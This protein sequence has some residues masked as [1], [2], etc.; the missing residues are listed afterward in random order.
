MFTKIFI[1]VMQNFSGSFFDADPA[2][3]TST[4]TTPPSS[5]A[6]PVD[7]SSDSVDLVTSPTSL[8]SVNNSPLQSTATVLN[9]ES[10]EVLG[11]VADPRSDN[12]SFMVVA[13]S[14]SSTP[15]S[16]FSDAG[17]ETIDESIANTVPIIVD[18]QDEGQ[19][20]IEEE[21]EENS[22]SESLAVTIMEP[23]MGNP[24]SDTVTIP[25]STTRQSLHLNL[26]KSNDST[27]SEQTLINQNV[28]TDSASPTLIRSNSQKSNNNNPTV[29]SLENYEMQTEFSDSTHSFEEV[30]R[31]EQPATNTSSGDELETATSSDIEIISNP[32]GCDGNSST[33]SRLSPLKD[34]MGSASVGGGGHF[35]SHRGHSRYIHFISDLQSQCAF[36]F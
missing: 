24:P 1:F 22:V 30:P 8:S 25:P 14:A 3:A 16:E 19:D 31:Q 26:S 21:E 20:D 27:S 2:T 33:H 32:N 12:S 13:S 9:S 28:M 5:S 6:P 10:I 34:G 29:L 11:A 36:V 15:A 35:K 18:H 17:I 23:R 7:C 4:V